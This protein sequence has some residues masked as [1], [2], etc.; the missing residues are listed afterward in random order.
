MNPQLMTTLRQLRLSGLGQSLQV[1][2][3][4]AAA[5]QLSHQE[6]LELIVQDELAVRQQRKLQHRLRLAE[7]RLLKPLELRRRLCAPGDRGR[8]WLHVFMRHWLATRLQADR[9]HL[10]ARLPCSFSVGRQPV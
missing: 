1:R 7:F 6:F 8:E 10:H 3:Q 2:L 9:P 5:S 4:E